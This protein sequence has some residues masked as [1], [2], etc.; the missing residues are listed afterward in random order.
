MT[1][2]D[3]PELIFDHIGIVAKDVDAGA[4]QLAKTLGAVEYT[5]RFDDDALRVSVRFVRDRGGIVYELIAP[6]GSESPV[7][8]ALESRTNLLNQI[9]YRTGALAEAARALRDRGAFPLGPPKPARAFGGAEVQFFLSDLGFVIE[10]IGRLDI[11]HRF[12]REVPMADR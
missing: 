7:T 9:A 6:F 4:R 5:Q 1:S 8:K 3:G 10:L 2:L 12:Y 11:A